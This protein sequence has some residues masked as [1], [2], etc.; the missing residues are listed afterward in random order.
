LVDHSLRVLQNAITLKDAF[1][2]DLPKESLIITALFHDL[3]KVGYPGTQEDQNYYVETADQWRRDKLGEM[4]TYNRDI[5]YMSVPDRSLYVLQY[6]G[7][8]LTIDETLAIRLH[9]G[10]AVEANRAYS[11]KEPP[12]A[13]V[14]HMADM[15]ATKQEKGILT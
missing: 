3:G 13:D 11:M 10:L 2:W 12:L 1:E 4:Y 5:T 8:R 6:Y 9:D 7:V 15:I 14:L